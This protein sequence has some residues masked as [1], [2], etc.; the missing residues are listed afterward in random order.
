MIK[1]EM[2]SSFSV[3]QDN[4]AWLPERV[5]PNRI[6][7]NEETEDLGTNVN[8]SI[9]SD[10]LGVVTMIFPEAPLPTI[11]VITESETTVNEVAAVSPKL[12]DVAVVKFFPLIVIMPLVPAESGVNEL[13]TGIFKGSINLKPLIVSDPYADV[14]IIFP[15]A[16][17]PTIAVITESETTVN[18]MA[19]V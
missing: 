6:S 5:P 16:P 9:V 10:P 3:C 13:M 15:E 19:D 11:A 2:V 18:E 17:L 7:T 1:K 8:L 14:T 12:T 4:C